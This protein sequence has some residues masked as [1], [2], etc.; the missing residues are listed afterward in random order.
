MPSIVYRAGNAGS[1]RNNIFIYHA[2]KP[3]RNYATSKLHNFHKMCAP[4]FASQV[5]IA[6]AYLIQ[7]EPN[8]LAT[9]FTIVLSR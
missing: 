3:F 4:T 8:E 1:E 5:C 7:I 6:Y 2:G 9:A